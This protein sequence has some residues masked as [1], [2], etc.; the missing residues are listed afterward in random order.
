ML[1]WESGMFCW[2]WGMWC[3]M[4]ILLQGGME[5]EWNGKENVFKITFSTH[6]NLIP[7]IYHRNMRKGEDA[8][9]YSKPAECNRNVTVMCQARTPPLTL[10]FAVPA[11][12][13]AKI[14]LS[15][16]EHPT[17]PLSSANVTSLNWRGWGSHLVYPA[18]LLSPT[19]SSG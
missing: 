9:I 1:H 8:S 19:L 16:R 11:T 7:S 13:A 14:T 12:S 2:G 3:G 10:I 18:V 17:R 4:H 5:M 6:E 15:T